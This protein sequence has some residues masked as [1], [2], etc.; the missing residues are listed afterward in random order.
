M[1][2]EKARG[3][4]TMVL[5]LYREIKDNPDLLRA[6]QEGWNIFPVQTWEQLVEFARKFSQLRYT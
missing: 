3:G 4:G 2:L 1:A 5:N 6:S